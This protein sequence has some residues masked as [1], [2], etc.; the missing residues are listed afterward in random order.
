[1]RNFLTCLEFLTRIR[2]TRRTEWRDDDFSRCVPYFPFIGL[3]I[4]AFLGGVNYLL[5]CLNTP[6]FLRA[7]LLVLAELLVAGSLMYDGFMDT[8]DGIFSA[9][10]RERML[11]IMK[12]SHVGSNAVIAIICL[13]LLKLAAYVSLD[14]VQ[15]T[16]VLV[17]MSI[18]TRAFMVNYIVN[19]KYA[20]PSG[21]GQ[22]FKRYAHPAYVYLVAVLWLTLVT[23]CG[24]PYLYLEA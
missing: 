24:L 18:S 12:D 22:M 8:A 3:L 20:R 16:R 15:L 4:G 11:E 6:V 5:L 2:F 1:M 13:I 10:S 17:A 19:F 9:R 14:A 21:I 23:A 7:S